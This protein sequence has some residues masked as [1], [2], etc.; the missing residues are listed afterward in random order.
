M[1]K[2]YNNGDVEYQNSDGELH[3]TVGP[4]LECANG[5]KHWYINGKLLASMVSGKVTICTEGEIPPLIKQSIAIE[6]LK[7]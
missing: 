3:R 6:V 5:D 1:K 2:V 7:V 4:T